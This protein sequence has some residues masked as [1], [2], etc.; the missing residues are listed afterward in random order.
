MSEYVNNYT[1][2]IVDD[3]PA[4]LR[5]LKRALRRYPVT[6]YPFTSSIK[7]LSFLAIEPVDML[8]TDYRMPGLDGLRLLKEVKEENP[9]ILRVILTGYAD[10]KLVIEAVN[11]GSVFKF[12]EKPLDN[13]S[14]FATMDEALA[15]IK[16]RREVVVDYEQLALEN[17]MAV[18]MQHQLIAMQSKHEEE[19]ERM[20]CRVIESK[21]P[22]LL[23][24]SKRVAERSLR[25]ATYLGLNERSKSALHKAC[26]FH[27]IGKIAIRDRVLFKEGK[28]TY[29]EFEEMKYHTKVGAQLL[30]EMADLNLTAAIVDQHHERYDG[31][32]YP[33]QVLGDNILIEARILTICDVFDALTSKRV[34]R[35][36]MSQ[37]EG[38]QF[39]QDHAGSHFDPAMVDK[40][41][42][43]MT[44][45][46][47]IQY[48]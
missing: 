10:M 20:L 11:E 44:Q 28:L 33:D 14:L 41:Y 5:A 3:D 12:H 8:I 29:T 36:A 30:R 19:V 40:F 2:V 7:A 22:D 37:E 31:K 9:D 13:A 35:D 6:I 26:L 18:D 23:E 47:R 1:V 45:I 32:G 21:D 16:Q 17:Q 46:E 15:L 27:D 24:H 43:W 4:T 48:A 42:T 38:L 34:Y 25:F 39:L